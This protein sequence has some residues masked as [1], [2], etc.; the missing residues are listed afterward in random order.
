MQYTRENIHVSQ[1]LLDSDNPRHAEIGNQKGIIQQLLKTEQIYKLAE[2][3]IEQKSLSPL[4][5][6][7]VL[8]IE[9]NEFIVLEGNRRVLACLL[10]NNPDMCPDKSL[11][12]KF[13][14]LRKNGTIPEYIECIIFESRESSDHWIELRH[15]GQ[16]EGIGTKRWDA[17]QKARHSAK[18]GKKNPNIQSIELID[19]AIHRNII[20]EHERDLFK[21][22]T[23]QRYLNNPIVRNVFGFES[24]DNLLSKHNE[25]IFLKLTTRFLED[26]KDGKDFISSRSNQSDWIAYGNMLA[27]EVSEPPPAT[28]PAINF[29]VK[30]EKIKKTSTATFKRSLPDPTKRKYLLP[31]DSIFKI[32]NVILRRIYNEIKKLQIDQHEFCVAYLLRAFIEGLTMLYLQ[33]HDPDK[34]NKQSKLNQ[35]LEY[36]RQNL[37]RKGVKK[38]KLRPLNIASSSENSLIS[39]L[40]I[41]SMVHLNIIPTKRELINMWDRLQSILEII[42]DKL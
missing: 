40:M 12:K 2:D 17:T 9:N 15:L 19:F 31:Y 37:E 1:M 34:L 3:I 4:E 30:S 13:K 38:S 5:I 36:V 28:N 20:K 41:G 27:K 8:P 7:G 25:K 11:I 29:S 35:K 33:K 18:Q 23:L 42:N 39:P 6:V 21:I 26:A 32:K 16:Q 10:L 24:S 22:T 14:N